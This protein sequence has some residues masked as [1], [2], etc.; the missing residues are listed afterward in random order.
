MPGADCDSN[1]VPVVC[2]VQV[3]VKKLKKSK[4][5][6]KFQINLVKT[7]QELKEHLLV[8]MSNEFQALEHV[9]EAVELWRKLRIQ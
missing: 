8:Y 4:Y 6:P 3:K 9:A 7:N 1:H 5:L 2:K